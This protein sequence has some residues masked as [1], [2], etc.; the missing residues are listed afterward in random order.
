M[1]IL[2]LLKQAGLHA[3]NDLAGSLLIKA[4]RGLQLVYTVEKITGLLQL[5]IR[6]G[7]QTVL[8]LTCLLVEL[9]QLQHQLVEIK[10]TSLPYLVLK[11]KKLKLYFTNITI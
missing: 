10:K 7:L 5:A 9:K 4:L 2:K 11:Q 1:A 6:T 8:V 3:I